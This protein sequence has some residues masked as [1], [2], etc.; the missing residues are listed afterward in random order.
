MPIEPPT[1]SAEQLADWRAL[2][3]RLRQ[4]DRSQVLAWDEGTAAKSEGTYLVLVTQ[5][6]HRRLRGAP[7]LLAGSV[8]G[9]VAVRRVDPTEASMI[10]RRRRLGDGGWIR[11]LWGCAGN[12]DLLGPGAGA[13]RGAA[14]PRLGWMTDHTGWHPSCGWSG[15]EPASH[16]DAKCR[17]V[18]AQ[19]AVAVGVDNR[20]I[21]SFSCLGPSRELRPNP[22]VGYRC[23]L[24]VIC[25]QLAPSSSTGQP[26]S[27]AFMASELY[28]R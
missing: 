10:L 7:L 3:E 18:A 26:K 5:Q 21:S 19:H 27:A 13:D 14:R 1:P 6:V 11:D 20:L 23:E 4:G 28:T 15:I 16:R 17:L 24:G 25:R 12:A 2:I 9:I 22:A 8:A